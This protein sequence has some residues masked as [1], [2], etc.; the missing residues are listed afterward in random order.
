MFGDGLSSR[1]IFCIHKRKLSEATVT[2]C[3]FKIEPAKKYYFRKNFEKTDLKK[4]GDLKAERHLAKQQHSEELD[5]SKVLAQ[6]QGM[7]VTYGQGVII[8]HLFSDACITLDLSKAASLVGNV[9]LYLAEADN[10]YSNMHFLP[11]SALKRIG[12]AISYSDEVILGNM[13]DGHYFVHCSEFINSRDEGLEINGSE[14]K[15]E[16]Q[17]QLF[18]PFSSQNNLISN[19]NSLKPGDVIQVFNGSNGG[20]YLA[21]PKIPLSEIAQSVSLITTGGDSQSQLY[22]TKMEYTYLNYDLNIT[23]H[24][25]SSKMPSFYTLWEIQKITLFDSKP[26]QYLKQKQTADC[27][28]RLKNLA[29]H[30]YLAADPHDS[31]RLILT[32]DGMSKYNVFYL[33][34]KSVSIDSHFVRKGDIVK[35]RNFEG[36]LIQPIKLIRDHSQALKG[37]TSGDEKGMRKSGVS[38]S[39]NIDPK[40]L[41]T[42]GI[43][44][45]SE[46]QEYT[47]GCSNRSDP[48]L[49][50]F[51]IQESQPHVVSVANKLSSIY[52][53]LINFY[54]YFQDWAITF[55]RLQGKLTQCYNYELAEKYEKELESEID[56]LHQALIAAYEFLCLGKL[57]TKKK[58]EIESEKV[59]IT[60]TEGHSMSYLW[61]KELLIDQN[62]LELL[63]LILNLINFKTIDTLRTAKSEKDEDKEPGARR[64]ISYATL[65]TMGLD[66]FSHI[67]QVIAK[68]R[69]DK[70]TTL[71]L[72]VLI[73]AALDSPKCS[74][75]LARCIDVFENLIEF[76]PNEMI[77]LGYEISQ[78]LQ[79]DELTF[80]KFISAWIKLLE[81]VNEKQSGN[82]KRQCLIL[83]LLE[84]LTKNIS[85]ESTLIMMQDKLFSSLY[86]DKT[87]TRNLKMLR[88]VKNSEFAGDRAH[89]ENSLKVS[90]MITTASKQL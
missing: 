40:H 12:E 38:N 73:L 8:R 48:N 55:E 74:Y 61:L 31:S 2:K 88:F 13:K 14:L 76:R 90:F 26:P 67:P 89:S 56:L 46:R 6:T 69:L 64:L 7:P 65:K 45:T 20:G 81:E 79:C 60:L 85:E 32:Q 27:A 49:T 44:D 77:E 42:Q 30:Y 51:E 62:I 21:S 1:R 53:Q 11:A 22:E 3:L 58:F 57:E 23:I 33:S 43:F 15:T 47:F 87:N 34:S 16:W 18:L 29:T 19:S 54:L 10:E 80:S 84:G 59:L 24:V 5:Y 35:I 28:I 39:Q 78:H 50:S 86:L 52:Y 68:N 72:K 82:I 63:E 25:V 4:N 71:I 75:F 36:R 70:V 83:K 41:N 9:R 66:K 17:P 37:E